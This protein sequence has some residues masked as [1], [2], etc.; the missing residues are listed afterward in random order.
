MSSVISKTI[1]GNTYYYLATSARVDGKPRIVEQT[2]L[3]TAA[4]IAAAMAGATRMPTRSRHLAF[5]DLAAA[6]SV[7]EKLGVVETVDEVAGARRADAGASVGTYL[8]LST[9]NRVVDPCSKS[10]FAD[11]WAGTAG[12]RLLKIRPA[13]LDSRR[14]WDATRPL[15]AT[16]LAEIERRIALRAVAAFGLDISSLA[17]D[18]TNFASFIDSTNTRAS[19]AQRGKA[20]QKRFDLRLVGLGLVVTRDGGIPLVS[21]AYPGNKTDVTQFPAVIDELSRRH[22]LLGGQPGALTVVFDAGQNSE[23]NFAKLTAAKL[24]YVGSLPPSDCP[25]LLA[26]PRTDYR[27]V[28]AFQGL[29]AHETTVQAL[30]LAHRCVLTHSDELHAGQS[31]GLDQALAKAGREL[32]GI[33]DTLARGRARRTRA[34][35][36][37]AIDK[38][39]NRQYVRD[40]LTWTLTGDAPPAIRLDWR[41]D[42]AARAALED[43]VFGKRVLITD[44]RDWTI[45][46]IVAGYRSQSEAEF[47]FRQLKDPQVV[48]FSP[49]HHHTDPHIRVHVFCCVLALMTA[50]LMR[51]QAARAGLQLSVRALLDALAGIQQTVL[52]YPGDRGRPKARRM[53]TD[54]SDTQQR[55]FEIFELHRWAPAS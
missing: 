50:H 40:V 13:A 15:D 34:Q 16:A 20:K 31:R 22:R 41:V 26:I 9:L 14:Y 10:A 52:L 53:I 4:E 36:E 42:E 21:H 32:D 48:S 51:R 6:W 49:M 54:M 5:G 24:H 18:M 39:A 46:D 29:R 8:A 28:A 33:Q 43:R 30:G 1:K 47:G 25:D 11:W 23:P 3:G 17:L 38:I 19:L 12:D 2:Y 27:L 7:I 37:A 44:R 45:P 55:L 35:L